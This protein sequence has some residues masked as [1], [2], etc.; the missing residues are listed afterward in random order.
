MVEFPALQ[1]F[2]FLL[3][4][5]NCCWK[6]GLKRW[7]GVKK[8]KKKKT[9]VTV[10][11]STALMP[12]CVIYWLCS[13]RWTA[14]LAK[15]PGRVVKEVSWTG[16]LSELDLQCHDRAYRYLK[17]VTFHT[18]AEMIQKQ[19]CCEMGSLSLGSTVSADSAPPSFARKDELCKLRGGP[20]DP[21]WNDLGWGLCYGS[22]EGRGPGGSVKW[23]GE[24]CSAP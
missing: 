12:N 13:S 16:S 3:K 22:A 20:G 7:W 10:R 9:A 11:I 6:Y 4:L 17:S 21:F 24:W 1:T 15:K 2:L 8:K 19:C 23:Q 18:A 14:L 5:R